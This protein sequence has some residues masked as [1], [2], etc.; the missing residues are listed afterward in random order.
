MVLTMPRLKADFLR[1]QAARRKWLKSTGRLVIDKDTDYLL[2][3]LLTLLSCPPLSSSIFTLAWNLGCI[4]TLDSASAISM[5]APELCSALD[6]KWLPTPTSSIFGRLRQS[7]YF[8]L[9]NMWQIC[10]R[11]IN[12][13]IHI[14]QYFLFDSHRFLLNLLYL[15]SYAELQLSS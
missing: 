1:L 12:E 6:S 8:C 9:C 15:P 10:I 14:T 4:C 5:L 13:I 2:S 7:V 11:S 3:V